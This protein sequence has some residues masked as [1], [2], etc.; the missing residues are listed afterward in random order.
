MTPAAAEKRLEKIE[1]QLTPKEWAIRLADEHR[2]YSSGMEHLRAIAKKPRQ[3]ILVLRGFD[4]LEK[5]AEERYP[6]NK[7]ADEQQRERLHGELRKEYHERKVILKVVGLAVAH[8]MEPLSLQTALKLSQ[9]HALILQ[10]MLGQAPQSAP[11]LLTLIEDWVQDVRPLITKILALPVAVELVENQHFDGHKILLRDW[12]AQLSRTVAV[13]ETGIVAFNDYL[14]STSAVAGK[15]RDALA[16]NIEAIKTSAKEK[17][18]PTLAAHWLKE[19][20]AEAADDLLK[21]GGGEWFCL[22][23]RIRELV[24]E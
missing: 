16:I 3:E 22:Q 20:A 17:D 10:D 23:K 11:S 13:A 18:G 9:L 6:G 2:E 19:A 14:K 5:Q 4:A 12:E 15:Q 21:A 7:P 24:G 8:Q 1:T